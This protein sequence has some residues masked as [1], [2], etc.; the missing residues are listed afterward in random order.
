MSKGQRDE[1]ATALLYLIMA[2]VIAYAVVFLILMLCVI[3][4]I[5][6]TAGAGYL[7]YRV[8]LDSQLWKDRR[9]LKDRELE[10]ARKRE[11][12]YYQKSGKGWMTQVVSNYYDDKERD[13]YAKEIS[14]LDD[15]VNSIRKIRESLK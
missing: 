6:L 3:L 5:S 15:A 8:A 12:K 13:L 4:T 2:G 10:A 14:R 1:S 9:V 11:L 7:G